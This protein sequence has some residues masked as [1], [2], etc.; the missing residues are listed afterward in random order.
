MTFDRKLEYQFGVALAVQDATLSEEVLR[1]L[2]GFFEPKTKLGEP[3]GG[4]LILQEGAGVRRL[5]TVMW[6]TGGVFRVALSP[7]RLDVFV[8]AAQYE[9]VA[10]RS[11]SLEG[12]RDR[13]VPGLIRAAASLVASGFA[14]QRLAMIL[15]GETSADATRT[16]A[17]ASIADYCFADKVR[18]AVRDGEVIDLG[19]RIDHGGAVDLGAGTPVSLHRIENLGTSLNYIGTQLNLTTRVTLDVNTS[20]SR[21][22]ETIPVESFEAFYKT[23]CDW[24]ESR[25]K[26]LPR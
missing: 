1:A 5:P 19:A 15:N 23:A 25:L 22:T 9:S 17:L 14:I 11:L 12:A 6:G 26:E 21:G 2:P 7:V 3:A 4:E 10:E 20:P 18:A 24:I 8:D 13:M 16:D